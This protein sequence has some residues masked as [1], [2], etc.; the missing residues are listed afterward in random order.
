MPEE[1]ASGTGSA[2]A[3]PAGSRR[4]GP[5]AD[6]P[7]WTSRFTGTGFVVS[8]AGHVLTNRHVVRPWTTDAAARALLERGYVPKLRKLTGY[9]PGRTEPFEVESWRPARRLI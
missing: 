3:M 2:V 6:G 8:D 5:G 9:L 1:R 7:V 4:P